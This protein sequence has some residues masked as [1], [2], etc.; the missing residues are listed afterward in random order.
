MNLR[1]NYL[2]FAL[3]FIEGAFIC[4]NGWACKFSTKI[5]ASEK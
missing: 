3:F 1:L 5:F 4:G 2:N